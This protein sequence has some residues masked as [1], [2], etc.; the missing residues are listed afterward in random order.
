MILCLSTLVVE[1]SPEQ[2]ILGRINRLLLGHKLSLVLDKW[3]HRLEVLVSTLTAF[4]S[5]VRD[6]NC[7]FFF[8]TITDRQ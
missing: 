5:I 8:I 6:D 2:G 1:P 7:A 3:A 4:A